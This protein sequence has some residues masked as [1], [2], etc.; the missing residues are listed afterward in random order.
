MQSIGK[1]IMAVIIILLSVP[2]V[3][4]GAMGQFAPKIYSTEGEILLDGSYE[5][6][7]FTTANNS[8]SRSNTLFT[9]RFILTTTGWVYHPR[10][11]IFLA[12]IGA[13]LAH[14][15]ITSD[16]AYTE[17]QGWSTTFMPEYELR[18]VLLPEHDYNLELYTLRRD[19]YLP[20]TVILG[21]DTVGTDTGAIFKYKRRPWTYSLAYNYTTL[22]SDR[23]STDTS[24][25]R[26]NAVY[27]KDWG[28]FAG[29]YF[30]EDSDNTYNT[31]S[32]NLKTD[33]YSLEN[34]LRFWKN[35]GYLTSN[36]SEIRFKQD[37]TFEDLDDRRRT[38]NERLNLDLPW[39]FNVNLYYNR[40]DE[41]TETQL[42]NTNIR[43]TLDNTSDTTGLTIIHRLYQSL[44]TSYNFTSLKITS[45]TGDT[46]GTV[47]ALSTVY[48][49]KIPKGLM[50]AGLS[51]SYS[52]IDRSGTPTILNE[53]DYAQ[54]F[55]EFTLQ[56]TD[57]NPDTI[58]IRIKS[59]FTNA[60]V[61]LVKDTHY[62]VILIG[63]T[64]RIQIISIPPSVLS[65]D[66]FYLYTFQVTYELIRDDATITTTTY[67]G[68]LKLELFDNS[69]SPYFSYFH[70]EQNTNTGKT[71]A[72]EPLDDTTYIAGIY[73]QKQPYSLLL[74]YQDV[75]SNVNPYTLI[76]A[77][78]I[79]RKDL[80]SYSRLHLKALYQ[81]TKHDETFGQDSGFTEDFIGATLWFQR[82]YPQKNITLN[83]GATY[84]R[85][86]GLN[87][88]QSYSVDGELLWMLKQF[89]LRAGA[90]IGYTEIEY[91]SGKQDS[92]YQR[93]TLSVR[94]QIF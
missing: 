82:R 5:N 75:Q 41:T 70:T 69:V 1:M 48:T 62:L 80:S 10:F 20:G 92:L 42:P 30:H 9:E 79:Y 72:I 7:Q 17:S 44:V 39:H 2:T 61:G 18:A 56:Q 86:A 33:E 22:D 76:K 67:G 49:K 32:T 81:R 55:G 89:E 47:N 59:P 11:L 87:T 63:N 53:T 25:L 21:Y 45:S 4:Q 16:Y 64:V 19:R 34:Q 35:R 71:L 15:N 78:A 27:F 8:T 74:E 77:E 46:K 54:L 90:G 73:L 68:S 65:P 57:L 12:K 13:G 66:P 84:N 28:T 14:E 29:G 51:Y 50:I 85:S 24:T 38:W 94:R 88:R 91:E 43:T 26:T 31:V 23:Y 52:D 3:A 93:Y 58:I 37:S 83:V 6:Q 60:Y 36:W 40:Y